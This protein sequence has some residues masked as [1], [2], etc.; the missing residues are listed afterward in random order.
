[1]HHS[2]WAV[3]VLPLTHM[4]VSAWVLWAP[5]PG[6]CSRGGCGEQGNQPHAQRCM[7][8]TRSKNASHMD[9]VLQDPLPPFP[10][11]MVDGYAVVAADGPGQVCR[12]LCVCV[13]VTVL[14]SRV[15]PSLLPCVSTISWARAWLGRR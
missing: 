7:P 12:G 10:A 4:W 1:M 8:A 3:C 9:M 5:D 6:L 13:R 15:L 11:S 14:G 2:V